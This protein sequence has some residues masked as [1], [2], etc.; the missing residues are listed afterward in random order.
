MISK[1]DYPLG[2]MLGL[3][4]LNKPSGMTSHDVV[5]VVRRLT[6]V[7]QVGHAGTLDPLATGVLLVLVGPATRLARYLSGADKTYRAVIRLGITTTTYDAEGDV[8]EQ[9]PVTVERVDIETALETFRGPLL[10]TP[11]MVSA[12]KVGGQPLYKLARKGQE[13]ERQPRPVAIHALILEAWTPP[14]LTLT[15]AC[16][17]GTYIRSLAYD[18]GEA[19][20]C[21]GHVAA[22]ARTAAG[23]FRLAD[24]VTLE[25]LR[26]LAATGR[27]A[28]ALLPPEAA[29]SALPAV[30]LTPEAEIAARY[31][32]VFDLPDAPEALEVRAHDAQGRL[33]GVLIPTE[34]ARWRPTL[35]L[36]E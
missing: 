6:G 35:V 29:L 5:N 25:Q 19:L 26:A 7:R 34:D 18:L 31:G 32:Q 4:N 33:V 24:S 2:A 28:E 16:S 9:R 23:S 20:G 15:V 10:Q 12:L 17:A 14:D 36:P 3:L 1:R 13:I 8:V 27:L 11:P 30:T 21:G 22:L